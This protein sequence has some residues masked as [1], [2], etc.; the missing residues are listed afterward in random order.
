MGMERV[1]VDGLT[2]TY[3]RAGSG[4][5]L[6]LLHGY[7]GDGPSVWRH[8]IDGLAS[9][10]TV[11][12]W[13]APGAGASSDPPETFGIDG[14]AE[15][16]AGLLDS[17]G[18]GPAHIMGLSFGGAL[19]LAF[20]RRHQAWTKTLVLASA[21]AGWRGSLGLEAAEARLAQAI[22]LSQGSP[23]ELVETLL[24]TMFALPVSPD[25]LEAHRAAMAAF[26]PVGFRAMAVA[27]AE[28]V[29]DVL[30]SIVVP[31]L[32]VY[33]DEDVRAPLEVAERLRASIDSSRLVVLEGAGH[34]CNVELP[35][36]FNAEVREF[37]SSCGP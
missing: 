37:L 11:V 10:F 16:L 22:R 1:D 36:R 24:P 6:M 35:E 12:A 30:S 32:L 34:V 29:S 9:D 17:L 28:D 13:N 26:H 2:I 18:L 33:G 23:D 8:Q 27:S 31:T 20:Q 5:L 4:P 21:Y 7:L 15:C 14:Y 19:A 25:D 3:E